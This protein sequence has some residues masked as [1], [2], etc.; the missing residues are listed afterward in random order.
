MTFVVLAAVKAARTPE[1]T[2][3]PLLRSVRDT[4]VDIPGYLLITESIMLFALAFF[5]AREMEADAS[6]YQLEGSSGELFA[7][8]FF[9]RA[10]L[11]EP[12]AAET[13][14]RLRKMPKK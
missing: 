12:P 8:A 10:C 5:A 2:V 4:E 7:L 6:E 13:D 1:L 14:A 3:A 9:V 11:P